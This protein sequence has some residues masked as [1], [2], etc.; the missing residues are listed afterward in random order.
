MKKDLLVRQNNDLTKASYK[1]TLIEK[2]IVLLMISKL[3]NQAKNSVHLSLNEY[4]NIFHKEHAIKKREL[5]N[6]ITTL[7][8]REIS[9]KTEDKSILMRWVYSVLYDYAKQEIIIDINERLIPYITEL[10][11]HFTSYYLDKIKDL[12]S[13]YSVRLYEMLIQFKS[14]NILKITVDDYRERLNLEHKYPEFKS[15][16]NRT[17]SP[18]IEEINKKTDLNVQ[19]REIKNG[20]KVETLEFTFKQTRGIT[21][22]VVPVQTDIEDFI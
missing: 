7:F 8:S 2:R 3:D 20:R 12:N 4:N 15:L 11:K 6:A 19:L 16:K 5:E 1:L 17:I 21:G 10:K 14:T 9:I 22:Q 18:A 13:I